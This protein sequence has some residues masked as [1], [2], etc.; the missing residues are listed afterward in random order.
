MKLKSSRFALSSLRANRL[1]VFPYIL[2]MSLFYALFFLM[3]SLQENEFVCHRNEYLGQYMAVGIIVVGLFIFAI[4]FYANRFLTKRRSKEFALYSVLGLEK[5]HIRRI[6]FFEHLFFTL[7]ISLISLVLGYLLGKFS[8]LF[9]AKL[10]ELDGASFAEYPFSLLAAMM[11]G[12]FILFVQ[13]ILFMVNLTKMSLSSPMELFSSQVKGEKEPKA[14]LLISLLGILTT[15]AG[16][17]IALTVEG[18]V[19]AVSFFFLA[20]ILV[21]IGTYCLFSSLSVFCLKRMK[22]RDSYYSKPEK[23]ISVSGMLYRM[24]SNALGLGSIAILS[25]CVIISLATTISIHQ[26]LESQVTREVPLDYKLE[27]RFNEPTN[28]HLSDYEAEGERIL[29]LIESASPNGEVDDYY[30]SCQTTF[31]TE[32]AGNEL[33]N[34]GQ[35]SE[36]QFNSQAMVLFAQYNPRL[37]KELDI[38]LAEGELLFYSESDRWK[39]LDQIKLFGKEYRIRT[40]SELKEVTIFPDA[41]FVLFPSY[42]DFAQSTRLYQPESA[43]E[44]SYPNDHLLLPLTRYIH[45]TMTEDQPTSYLRDLDDELY[46][47]LYTGPF[48]KEFSVTGYRVLGHENFRMERLAFN[49]GFLFLGVLVGLIFMIG[50]VLVTYYKQISEGYEDRTQFQI[51]KRVGLPDRLIRKTSNQQILW[52]FFLPLLVALIHILVSGRIITQL[53]ILFGVWDSVQY[54]ISLA[55]VSAV[56]ALFY[57]ITFKITSRVYY[58]IVRY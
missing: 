55:A 17:Y 39:G 47:N 23:F 54:F 58:R 15:G 53:L 8:F 51:M 43:N 13:T 22:K 28:L 35:I 20:V 1:F 26:G 38:E 36:S 32:V 52:M 4:S 56:F 21:I 50:T 33:F 45:W 9:L 42:D 34:P 30:L 18:A 3:S 11:T 2:A 46:E 10:L 31:L 25:T 7:V 44:R 19:S 41:L 24:K 29:S 37:L 5:K 49:G 48:A 14:S 16:Y 57:F 27:V 12:A 40:C 6:L